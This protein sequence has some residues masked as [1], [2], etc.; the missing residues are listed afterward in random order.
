M[1]L[2][3]RPDA[4]LRTALSGLQ[5]TT[6]IRDIDRVLSGETLERTA[7]GESLDE[8]IARAAGYAQKL[9][10]K[11]K[12]AEAASILSDFRERELPQFVLFRA[13]QPT[14]EAYDDAAARA[15]TALESTEEQQREVDRA[16]Q[17]K[18]VVDEIARRAGVALPTA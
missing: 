6:Q 16:R 15:A 14:R 17:W 5:N 10:R 8:Q 7:F 2:F 1:G 11:G 13:E 12:E 3:S 18:A 4:E 9:T